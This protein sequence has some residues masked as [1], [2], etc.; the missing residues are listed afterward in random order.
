L[1]VAARWEALLQQLVAVRAEIAGRR[2]SGGLFLA[3][4][5]AVRP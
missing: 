5:M 4:H 2:L 1:I 3:P